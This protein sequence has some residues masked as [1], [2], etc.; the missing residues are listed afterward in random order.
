M[1][2]SA[3]KF[4]AS[5]DAK[6][7]GKG[8]NGKQILQGALHAALASFSSVARKAAICC[9]SI[10]E[11]TGLEGQI[12]ASAATL[13]GFSVNNLIEGKKG[14]RPILKRIGAPSP[15]K[16]AEQLKRH[17]MPVS[18]L[19]EEAAQMRVH[20]FPTISRPKPAARREEPSF[21]KRDRIK[22]ITN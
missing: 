1:E 7:F 8:Q 12:D 11:F 5:P 10:S 3:K 13:M 2:N 17:I 14:T 18:T 19:K 15:S 21:R 16:V 4:A 6:S 20:F 22:T 9:D